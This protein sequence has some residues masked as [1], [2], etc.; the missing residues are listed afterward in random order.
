SDSS[1]FELSSELDDDTGDIED[2]NMSR[3]VSSSSLIE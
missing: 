1:S 3:R 2:D